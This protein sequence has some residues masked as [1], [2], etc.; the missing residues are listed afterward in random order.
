[1]APVGAREVWRG[2]E[3]GFRKG[4]WGSSEKTREG[5]RCNFLR[6]FAPVGFRTLQCM[7]YPLISLALAHPCVW[8]HSVAER[9][10]NAVI[11]KNAE[12]LRFAL[13][14]ALRVSFL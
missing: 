9:R 14:E 1:M 12:T 8:S 4:R 13:G 3:G 5:G 2:R 11:L 7:H 6:W 10:E